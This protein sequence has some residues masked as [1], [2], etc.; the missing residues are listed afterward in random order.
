[1]TLS[2][3]GEEHRRL[4]LERLAKHKA[5]IYGSDPARPGIIIEH[6]PDGTSRRGRMVARKFVETP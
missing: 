4:A 2:C 5:P 1:M 3:E 6:R